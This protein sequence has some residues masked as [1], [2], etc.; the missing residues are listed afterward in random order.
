MNFPSAMMRRPITTNSMWRDMHFRARWG[1]SFY[2]N[3][4]AWQVCLGCTKVLWR[5]YFVYVVRF[6]DMGT[7]W[8][9]ICNVFQLFSCPFSLYYFLTYL[10]FLI[11][12]VYIV[13]VSVQRVSVVRQ[14]YFLLSNNFLFMSQNV[15]VPA[16]D[17][18]VKRVHF[19]WSS[20]FTICFCTVPWLLHFFELQSTHYNNGLK[21]NT[22]SNDNI[23]ISTSIEDVVVTNSKKNWQ[24]GGRWSNC[25]EDSRFIQETP[26]SYCNYV[27]CMSA[28][29]YGCHFIDGS[30]SSRLECVF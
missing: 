3:T 23:L 1:R 24:Y 30:C 28:D 6:S 27:V 4:P 5:I 29:E 11:V 15:E 16:S 7:E 2:C 22:G 25:K 20:A 17:T 19:L 10:I 18:F 12:D 9:D 26:F 13:S 14:S 8:G 21:R